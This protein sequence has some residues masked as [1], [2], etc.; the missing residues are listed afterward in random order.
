MHVNA[1]AGGPL[2]QILPY[3][4]TFLGGAFSVSSALLWNKGGGKF[5]Y[6]MMPYHSI[7]GRATMREILN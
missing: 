5:K 2:H 7:G 6:A 1:H 4:S 3:Y